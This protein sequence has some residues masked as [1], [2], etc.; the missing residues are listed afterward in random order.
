MSG[1]KIVL[2]GV[3]FTDTSLPMLRDDPILSSGSL[4][5]FDPSHSAGT[6]AGVPAQGS[7]V[8]NVAW[9]EAAAIIGSGD[10]TTLAGEIRASNHNEATKML[11]ER[12]P[13]GGLHGLVSQV[14]Q[15]TTNY[16]SFRLKQ[17]LHNRIIANQD[18][19]Y[20][21]SI[22]HT[23]TRHT[24]GNAA[25][26]SPFHAAEST[27]NFIWHASSGAFAPGGGGAFG[28]THRS[29]DNGDTSGAVGVARFLSGCT[30]AKSG[31]GMGNNIDIWPVAAVLGNTGPWG[32]FN[33][34][35]APSRVIYRVYIED[36]T[37]SGRTY[38]Q[39]DSIDFALWQAAFAAGGKFYGDTYTDPSTLP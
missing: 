22:W 30:L 19:D 7:T 31:A 1:Q 25:P 13:K 20:Y 26:Q 28:G 38:A 29:P 16:Y 4:F 12:T 21:V 17:A 32:S 36:L 27:S 37:V 10:A 15:T 18:N 14:N 3:D 2:A 34:N 23:L 6:F 11:T 39:V 9:K 24:I 33:T 5:L 8:P 35:K